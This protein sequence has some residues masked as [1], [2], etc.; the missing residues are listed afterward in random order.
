M[1]D[2]ELFSEDTSLKTISE[3]IMKHGVNNGN[4]IREVAINGS[5]DEDGGKKK[6]EGEVNNNNDGD[7]YEVTPD[8]KKKKKCLYTII[9]IYQN[10]K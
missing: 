7:E 9:F 1:S 4:E 10:G 6:V 5:S 3:F 2:E 8:G